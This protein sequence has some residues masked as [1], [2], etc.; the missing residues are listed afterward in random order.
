MRIDRPLFMVNLTFPPWKAVVASGLPWIVALIGALLTRFLLIGATGRSEAGWVALVA[1][2]WGVCLH[3]GRLPRFD[4]RVLVGAL[5]LRLVLVGS[6]PLLSDDLYRYL[7]EGLA[8]NVGE[9]PYLSPPDQ[10][11][12]VHPG[13]LEQINHPHLAS[14]YPPLGL[15]WFRFLAWS[16]GTVWWIQGCTAGIDVI[17]V[18]LLAKLGAR[19]G[20]ETRGAA[21]YALH[22]IPIL[23]CAVGGHIDTLALCLALSA[24][25][26]RRGFIASVWATAGAFTKLIPA[27]LLGVM[28]RR[29]G[30]KPVL[31]GALLIGFL[32]LISSGPL[33]W[34]S[35]FASLDSLSLFTTHWSFNG[36][37]Y[38]WLMHLCPELARPLLAVMGIA[39]LAFVMTRT[40]R[41]LVVLA[42]IGVGMVVCSP[43]LHPWYVLW[44]FAPLSVLVGASATLPLSFLLGGYAVLFSLQGD[45]L[46]TEPAWLWAVTW[47]PALI[48]AAYC[49]FTSPATTTQE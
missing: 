47:T 33:I 19:M 39:A 40:S 14:I 44:A 37:L 20:L 43:T 6:P 12:H 23:A 28:M 24:C 49:A 13:L 36:L 16:G 29:F 10:I 46:W 21:L 4:S 22:P 1:V 38:P 26:A 32:V 41:P 9:N 34:Q 25:L 45:G 2:V 35:G 8:L 42:S 48:T 11:P 30:P 3:L 18:V 31:L 7:W 15:L 17:N 5:C 27:L